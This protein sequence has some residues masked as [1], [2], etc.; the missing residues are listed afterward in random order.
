MEI[1]LNDDD[2]L[3][4]FMTCAT[5]AGKP[6]G[7]KPEELSKLWR[8]DLESAKRTVNVT[9]QNCVRSR[10]TGFSRNCSSNDR[11]HWAQKNQGAL[12]HGHIL[13]HKQRRWIIKRSHM[14]VNL[15]D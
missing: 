3:D 9:S 11:R 4:A 6:S 7:V 1:D 14:C 10:S 12:F 8:I 13:C 15:C 2:Q 5:S